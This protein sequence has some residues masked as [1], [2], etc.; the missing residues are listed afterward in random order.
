M[1]PRISLRSIRATLAGTRA[2]V[3]TVSPEEFETLRFE[4]LEGAGPVSGPSDYESMVFERP[5]GSL[6]GIR[7]SD[8][9]GATIDVLR[10]TSRSIRNGFRI[11]QK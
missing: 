10:S 1:P 6:I 9:Y 5:D 7:N 11:H 8:K 2:G 4:L 3:R